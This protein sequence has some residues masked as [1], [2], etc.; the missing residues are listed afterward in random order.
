MFYYIF[1]V[2]IFPR[3]EPVITGVS[4]DSVA[5]SW[6]PADIAAGSGR[7][8]VIQYRIETQYPPGIGPWEPIVSNIQ[9]TSY[10]VT[11]LH[12]DG[13]YMFR[14]RAV[15]DGI[16]SEPTQPVYLTRRAGNLECDSSS[17]FPPDI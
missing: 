5:L 4:Q 13:D 1:T 17:T 15:A 12:P 3:R 7:A 14:V 9:R 6:L 8:P 11:G 2:P 10:H 16:V